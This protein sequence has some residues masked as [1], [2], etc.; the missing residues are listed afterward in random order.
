MRIV[1][2]QPG[3]RA[4][5]LIITTDPSIGALQL[6]PG[7]VSVSVPASVPER[8]MNAEIDYSISPQFQIMDTL[9]P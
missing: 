3:Q 5:M 8:P 2:G 4:R 1:I 9:E 6:G 7:E